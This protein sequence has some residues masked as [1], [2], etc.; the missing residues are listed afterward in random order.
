[1]QAFLFIFGIGFDCFFRVGLFGR[2]FLLGGFFLRF[3]AVVFGGVDAA[4]EN[5]E[6]VIERFKN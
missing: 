5:E 4:F 6:A 2:F 3:L 1:M